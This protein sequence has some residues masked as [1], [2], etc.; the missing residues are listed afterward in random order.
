MFLVFLTFENFYL[1]SVRTDKNISYN[2]YQI[3][4]K[5]VFDSDSKKYF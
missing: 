1:L 3:G 2:H 5:S 4:F